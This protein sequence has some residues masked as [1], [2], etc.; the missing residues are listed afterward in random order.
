M[1]SLMTSKLPV[2]TVIRKSTIAQKITQHIG[3]TPKAAP[4]DAAATAIGSGIRYAKVAMQKVTKSP[5]RLAIQAG[6]LNNPKRT[7][8]VTIGAAAMRDEP[9]VPIP[10][11]RYVCCHIVNYVS[12]IRL[13]SD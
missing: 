9:T 12:G 11:N 13:S 2:S 3:K 4:F 1:E 6:R 5:L 8:I 10:N 7:S